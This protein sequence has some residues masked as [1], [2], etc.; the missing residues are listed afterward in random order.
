MRDDISTRIKNA[1][2]KMSKSQKKIAEA[3]LS[4]HGRI[5]YMT[6]SKLAAAVGTS[7]STVVR[8]AIEL[9]YEGYP[10][11]QGAVMELVRASLTP[12]QRIEMTNA[13]IGDSDVLD[14]VMGSD[15]AKIKYTL[16]HTDRRAFENAT[17][18]IVNAKSIYVIGARSSLAIAQFFAHN[19]SLIF[20]NVKLITASSESEVFEQTI[21]LDSKDVLFA[22]SFPRYSTRVIHAVDFAKSRGAK[23][24]ALTDSPASPISENADFLLTA[25]SDMASF[26]DSLVAPLSITDALIVAIARAKQTEI[27]ERF[28]ALEKIWDDY[29]VYAKR[30]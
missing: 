26:V 12:N 3:V 23:V 24:I 9:G 18:A 15:I 4:D 17:N 11:F 14:S 2:P 25:Q 16:E 7:E 30:K 5:A 13:L 8:F 20:D 1:L 29:N 27:R 6:A 19:L 28:D 22:V 21:S 10:E